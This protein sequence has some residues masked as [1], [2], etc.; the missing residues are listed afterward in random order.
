MNGD[1]ENDKPAS[2]TPSGSSSSPEVTIRRDRIAAKIPQTLFEEIERAVTAEP[3]RYRDVE[4]FIRTALEVELGFS[5]TRRKI[6]ARRA[7]EA[8]S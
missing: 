3:G 1:S 7:R 4:G 2:A 5:S 8:S 6:S